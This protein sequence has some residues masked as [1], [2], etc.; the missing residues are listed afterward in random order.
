MNVRLA[1]PRASDEAIHAIP[2]EGFKPA[3][4]VYWLDLF[5]SAAC[6][7]TALVLA[8]FAPGWRR[9]AFLLVAIVALYRAVLFIHEITHR[10][11]RDVPA[12]T[13]A[14]NALVGVPLCLLQAALDRTPEER[15]AFVRGACAD[16]V[17]LR[18]EVLSLLA[19]T[20][21]AGGFLETP[22]NE[23]ETLALGRRLGGYEIG[24]WIGAS[25]VRM[26]ANRLG[27]PG[28]GYWTS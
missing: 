2:I 22:S 16:D 26:R 3:P 19:H 9:G 12:F 4:A 6:G 27:S 23:R 21:S 8:I 20:A 24:A 28:A 10:A 1:E 13:L 15:E 25:S 7:W 5:T 17:A 18:D 11:A 14:W